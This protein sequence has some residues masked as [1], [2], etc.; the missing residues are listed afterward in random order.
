M[1]D[2]GRLW[3]IMEDYPDLFM[4]DATIAK[5]KKEACELT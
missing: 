4:G 5:T 3:K 2:Y 1:E